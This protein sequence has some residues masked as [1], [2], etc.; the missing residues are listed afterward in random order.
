MRPSI[1]QRYPRTV[2]GVATLLMLCTLMLVT[3][4]AAAT[5]R[6]ASSA[7]IT[8]YALTTTNELLQFNTDAPG[9][10][11]SRTAVTG[12]QPG[13]RLLG[14]DVR[15]NTGQLYALGSTSRVYVIELPSGAAFAEGAPFTPALDGAA[16]GFDFNP[17]VDRIRIVSDTGQNLRL[18]PDTGAVAAVDG[19]LAY[20]AADTNAGRTPG[21]A[22]SAYTNADRD[23]ATGT[24]LYNIDMRRDVLVVQNPP[25]DG[26]L[27]TVGALG[28][29]AKEL[30]GFD[31]V[32]ASTAY[33][34]L[35][36]D[37]DDVRGAALVNVNLATGQVSVI[38][39][40]GANESIVGLT[41]R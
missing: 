14:I 41:F 16:F 21:V 2:R 23:P 29:D 10:I 22:G 28:V 3:L 9:R 38:G 40:I 8:A 39:A 15:P 30:L 13:E 24:T 17:V 37:G 1:I 35:L 36:A 18:Q 31:I 6:V 5:T 19:R 33:A 27:Q 34:A 32:G 25:N 12:L 26:A 4:P 11:L 7:A 20:A